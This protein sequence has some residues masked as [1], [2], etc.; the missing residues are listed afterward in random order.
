MKSGT[1]SVILNCNKKHT[2]KRQ[3]SVEKYTEKRHKTEIRQRSQSYTND[4]RKVY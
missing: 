1:K 3:K 2:E 4:I